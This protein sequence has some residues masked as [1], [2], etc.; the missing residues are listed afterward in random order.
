M[1]CPTS[2]S[3]V[4][5]KNADRLFETPIISPMFL[6]NVMKTIPNRDDLYC[7]ADFTPIIARFLVFT[8]ALLSP[9]AVVVI[10]ADGFM[11]SEYLQSPMLK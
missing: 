9:A 7:Y 5:S 8:A 6:I 3:F 10:D 4:N 2:S 1:L 11:K